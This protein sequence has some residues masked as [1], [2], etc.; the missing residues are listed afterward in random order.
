MLHYDQ[1]SCDFLEIFI[2]SLQETGFI[3]S[4]TICLGKTLC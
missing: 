4:N 3:F 2:L 1:Q